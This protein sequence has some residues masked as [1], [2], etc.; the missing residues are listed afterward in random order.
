MEKWKEDL[1]N[2]FRKAVERRQREQDD[3]E[4]MRLKME[5]VIEDFYESKVKTA[6]EELKIELEKYGKKVQL[7]MVGTDA[8]GI[9]VQNSNSEEEFSYSIRAEITLKGMHIYPEIAFRDKDWK[10]YKITGKRNFSNVS[11]VTKEDIAQDFVDNIKPHI[12][13][14][15]K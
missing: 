10:R 12:Q 3:K 2:S 11:K 13:D 6:F 5:P 15:I 9:E 1:H 8:H 14:F 7:H 4:Q